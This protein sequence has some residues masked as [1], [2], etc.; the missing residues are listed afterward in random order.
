MSEMPSPRFYE[1]GVVKSSFTRREPQNDGVLPP[2]RSRTK[3]MIARSRESGQCR[4]VIPRQFPH[5]HF[6]RN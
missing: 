3:P 4:L 2:V 6:R 5:K 1:H